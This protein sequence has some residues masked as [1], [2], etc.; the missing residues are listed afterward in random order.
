MAA[1]LLSLASSAGCM[2]YAGP[3]AIGTLGPGAGELAVMRLRPDVEASSCR[4]WI[5]GVP[6]GDTS[7]DPVGEI[8]A[9]LL[10][11]EP[12]ATVLSDADVRWD[13]MALG[14]YE[15]Q[16]VTVR[17]VLGRTMPTITIPTG[18]DAHGHIH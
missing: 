1:T 4:R 10:A 17:G 2:R 8:V 18:A 14:L 5:L 11:R 16:C 12:D 3:T 15:R 6:V 7:D 9:E 13:H